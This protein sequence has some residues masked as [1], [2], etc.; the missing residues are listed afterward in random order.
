MPGKVN[1]NKW[2]EAKASVKK[3]YKFS[4]EN[5]RFWKLV[6]SVYKKMGGKFSKKSEKSL[7]DIIAVCEQLEK[8]TPAFASDK[9][10]WLKIER[11]DVLGSGLSKSE[12][13]GK[14]LQMVNYLCAGGRLNLVKN[15]DPVS[16]EAIL[17]SNIAQQFGEAKS[18][19]E[20]F[21]GMLKSLPGEIK[22]PHRYMTRVKDATT[23]RW[24][25]L[26]KEGKEKK[27]EV[28]KKKETIKKDGALT[29]EAGKETDRKSV[30]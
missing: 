12:Q 13:L 25:Y 7:A 26:Y 3:Q 20:F 5:P 29:K 27:A 28:E 11:E 18:L 14:T 23:G 30:V 6:S 9:R 15:E 1:E 17:K 8:S 24:K 2:S 22:Y 19:P 21:V 16:P 10:L 4:E